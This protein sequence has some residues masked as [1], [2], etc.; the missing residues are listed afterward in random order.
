MS[1][2]KLPISLCNDI[3]TLIRKFWWEQRGNQRKIHW[4]S[5]HSLCKSKCMGGLGFKDLQ[6]FNDSMLAKQVW[7]LLGNEDSLFHRLFKAKFFPNGSILDA[8][9]GTGSFAW[10]SILK[11][12]EVI[13]KGLRWRVGNGSEIRIFQ[14][15]W[16]PDHYLNRVLSPP[17]FLGIDARVFVLMD[18]VNRSWLHE[19]IDNLF[20]PHEA[21]MIKSLPIS[22]VDCEDKIFWPLTANGE[23][24]VKTGYRL[25]S[26]LGAS[27]NPSSSDIS[28]SKQ[29]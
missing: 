16:L 2:F 1:C 26:N 18:G 25:L 8:K 19:I 24:S 27:D 12:R 29:I 4:T 20:L 13:S 22:L 6:K 7:R 17:D 21:K 10:E 11:G 9:A 3:E 23:Y 14:D 15:N 5:W 28:L